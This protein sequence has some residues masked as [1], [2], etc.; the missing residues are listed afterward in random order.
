MRPF[1]KFRQPLRVIALAL[2][3]VGAFAGLSGAPGPA[4][5]LAITGIGLSAAVRQRRGRS[6]RRGASPVAA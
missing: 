3:L 1:L 4:V 6:T 5:V 2:L